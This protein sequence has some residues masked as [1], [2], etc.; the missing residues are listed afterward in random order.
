MSSHPS[1]EQDVSMEYKYERK[2]SLE[3]LPDKIAHAHVSSSSAA[4]AVMTS[5]SNNSGPSTTT[6]LIAKFGKQVI[7]L[8]G[9]CPESTT[10][11]SVKAMLQE[12]TR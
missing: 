4:A 9:L 6:T 11:G 1:D 5:S 10:I 2:S 3:S 12:H 7:T 8:R